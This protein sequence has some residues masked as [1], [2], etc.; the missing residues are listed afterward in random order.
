MTMKNT[1]TKAMVVAMTMTIA[2]AM[3]RLLKLF[4]TQT[5]QSV[6]GRTFIIVK[7]M[8]MTIAIAIANAKLVFQTD[9]TLRTRF[10]LCILYLYLYCVFVF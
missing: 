7:T 8:T 4:S 1:I 5:K 6:S 9:K 3:T 2:N 10:G